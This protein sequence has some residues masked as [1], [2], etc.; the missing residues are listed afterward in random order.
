MAGLVGRLE[1]WPLTSLTDRCLFGDSSASLFLIVLGLLVLGE[2][3]SSTSLFLLV[4]VEWNASDSLDE[5]DILSRM[6]L[7]L[8]CSF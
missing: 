5:L 3:L 4:N 8:S 2:T 1:V 6:S 7:C